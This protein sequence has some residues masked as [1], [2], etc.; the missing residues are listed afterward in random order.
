[1]KKLL[2]S[3]MTVLFLLL[4]ISVVVGAEENRIDFLL[5]KLHEKGPHKYAMIIAH[6]GDWRYAPENSIRGFEN[7]IRSGFDAIEVDVRMTKDS[8]LVIMH[9]ET[10]N[11]TTTGKGKVSDLTLEEIKKYK[12]KT[13]TN[14]VSDQTVPTFEEILE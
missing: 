6:R 11:R 9:D 8:V 4:T 12:L 10:I 13:P 7:C 5:D 2:F 3:L 14:Y 1:M